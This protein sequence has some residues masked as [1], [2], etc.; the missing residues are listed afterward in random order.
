MLAIVLMSMLF[1][2]GNF[3][4]VVCCCCE[5]PNREFCIRKTFDAERVRCKYTLCRSA[6]VWLQSTVSFCGVSAAARAIANAC[7]YRQWC[8]RSDCT[9]L[10]YIL[11]AD[12]TSNSTATAILLK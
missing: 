12:V 8:K 2:P 1:Q 10:C 11:A 6:F 7:N 5:R 4:L 9:E 3:D